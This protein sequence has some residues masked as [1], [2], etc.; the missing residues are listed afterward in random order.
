MYLVRTAEVPRV[1]HP[2]N[3]D[4]SVAPRRRRT[5]QNVEFRELEGVPARSATCRRAS[6][7]VEALNHRIEQLEHRISVHAIECAKYLNFPRGVHRQ[8]NALVF[9]VP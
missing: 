5:D 9:D 8:Q 1:D 7:I 2:R 6:H 3:L 4:T